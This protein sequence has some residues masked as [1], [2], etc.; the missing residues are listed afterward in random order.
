[1]TI[2]ILGPS[3]WLPNRLPPSLEVLRGHLPASRQPA[4]GRPLA[5]ID[6]RIALAEILS[7]RGVPAIV[8]EA[9][10]PKDPPNSTVKFHELVEKHF[11]E[12]YY[13]YWPYGA[14]RPGL[15]VELG[16]LLEQMWRREL[17]GDHVT[18]FYEDDGARR[19]AAGYQ[20]GRNGRLQFVS[21]EKHGKRTRYYP[22]LVDFGALAKD[23]RDHAELVE[24]VLA[25]TGLE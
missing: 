23:W 14:A 21:R 6:V 2:L 22:D 17:G 4:R 20:F 5:P 16:F 13:I 24:E 10:E 25:R 1:M 7:H 19:R 9:E 8:M 11:V 3:Q 18:V 12:D 15:D